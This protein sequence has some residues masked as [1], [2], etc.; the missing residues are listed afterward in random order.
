MMRIGIA[1]LAFVL[2]A[3]CMLDAEDAVETSTIESAATVL[4][5]EGFWLYQETPPITTNCDSDVPRAID[6]L[7]FIDR[8][9]STSYRVIPGEGQPSFLCTVNGEQFNCPN[10]MT[11]E[12]DIFGLDADLTFLYSA[13]G[14][15]TDPT[16]GTGKQ[17]VAVSCSGSHCGLLAPMPC[18]YVHNFTVR[19]L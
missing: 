18:G 8:I 4:P 3:G 19:A 9:S 15:H 14:I 6:D 13:T 10:R 7:I 5:V 1:C 11:R 12:I 16:R 2:S 17:D